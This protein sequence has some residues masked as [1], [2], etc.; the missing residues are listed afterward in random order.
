MRQSIFK[1]AFEGVIYL[2]DVTQNDIVDEVLKKLNPIKKDTN[3]RG[4]KFFENLAVITSLAVIFLSILL[5]EY[6]TGYCRA[7]NLPSECM[8]ID[9]KML[10]PFAA[11]AIFVIMF[12][13]AFGKQ[14]EQETREREQYYSEK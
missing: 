14:R 11:L 12:M 6:N 5:F 10:I 7:F 13:V 8:A 2:A 3:E 9:M 4:K 1:K